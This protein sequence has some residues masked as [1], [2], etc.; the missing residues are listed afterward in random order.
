MNTN[1]ASETVLSEKY[2]PLQK[3]VQN[4]TVWHKES[5]EVEKNEHITEYH[6]VQFL[7]FASDTEIQFILN[8]FTCQS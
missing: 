2:Q 3:C 6:F 7:P 8:L 4:E 1:R 5:A